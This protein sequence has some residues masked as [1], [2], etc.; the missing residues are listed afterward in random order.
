MTSR[1]DTEHYRELFLND[2]PLMDMRAPVEFNKGAFPCSEN[3]PLLDDKQREAVGTCYKQK[4]QDAAIELGWQLATPA[5]REQRIAAWQDF[6][7]RHPDGYLYC[8]RGGLRSR[9]SQQLV[10]EAGTAYPL[11]TGGYKAM[12]RFLIDE[13]ERNCTTMPLTLVSG[14]TGSGKTLVVHQLA[15]ALDLEGLANHRGSAFGRQLQPQPRQ[16][17]FENSLSIAV[18]K[19]RAQHQQVIFAEDEGRMIGGVTLPTNFIELMQKAPLAVLETPVAE[20][21][22][23]V[24]ADYISDA[25]P[26]YTAQFGAEEGAIKFRE[27]ILG[28]LTRIRKRLGGERFTQLH[29]EFS[30]ALDH[31]INHDDAGGFRSGIQLLL[32]DYYDPMYDYQQGQREGRVVFRGARAELLEWAEAYSMS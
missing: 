28:N 27:Q 30:D 11:V 15:H 21:I 23:I 24:L 29:A 18:M 10:G 31:L 25:Y 3:I 16:I 8:F 2:V 13:L 32:T 26:Q 19:Q 14:R 17:D 6:I 1:P 4:G 12:R 9:L 7:Q 5:I 20:R 22:D